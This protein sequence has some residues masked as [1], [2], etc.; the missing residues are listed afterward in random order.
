M[1]GLAKYLIEQGCEVSGSDV[2]GSKYTRT[3]EKLGAKIFIGHRTENVSDGATVIAST[4]IREDNPEIIR[5][6]ALGLPILHRSDLLAQIS[7]GDKFFIGYSGTHGKTTTSGLAAYVLEKAGLEPS[8]IVGGFVPGINTNAH[9]AS[10]KYFVAELDES[11]GTLTKYAPDIAAINNLEPDHLDFFTDGMEGIFK[12]FRQFATNAGSVIANNDCSGVN[13]LGC[14]TITFGLKDADYTARNIN[15]GT[16]FTTFEVN[17]TKLK[18]IL[19]GKHNVYN[20]L[21]VFASLVEAGVDP[22]KIAP[23]F[24]T[25]TGMGRR[26]EK[27]AEF[28]GI[29]VIDDYAHHPTEIKATLQA[30][31]GNVVAIFQPHRYTRLKELWDEFLT[32]FDCAQR[33]VVTDIYAASEDPIE[34]ITAEAFAAQLKAEHISGDMKVFAR[35]LLPTLKPGDIV[36]GM[37]AGTITYLGKEL[38]NAAG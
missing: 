9:C 2:E 32:S 8:F 11:D 27:V 15:Y 26:F 4:A 21:A 7:R 30:A 38:L 19:K 35:K 6:R 18:I 13:E 28:N 3:L 31:S 12:T 5:A 29:T 37:G 34:G 20:A 36:I 23:H 1:S 10:G 17:G 14:S 22:D 16:D 24:A 33:V 25:F